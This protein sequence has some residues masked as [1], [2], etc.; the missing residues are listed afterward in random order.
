MGVEGPVWG[1]ESTRKEAA[2]GE[3]VLGICCLLPARVQSIIPALG[4]GRL[5][6]L[7]CHHHHEL[8]PR[9]APRLADFW[10][11]SVPFNSCPPRG[12]PESSGVLWQWGLI[13]LILEI[14]TVIHSVPGLV[15]NL[16]DTKESKYTHLFT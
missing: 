13:H 1:M 9:P 4:L 3:I 6:C 11:P 7:Q 5:K 14:F 10:A 2:L 15:V 12:H 16:G 8:E